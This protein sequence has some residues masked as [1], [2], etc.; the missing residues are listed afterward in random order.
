L[1]GC[2]FRT[3]FRRARLLFAMLRGHNHRWFGPA[4]P[5]AE[6]RFRSSQQCAKPAGDSRLIFGTQFLPVA[7]ALIGFRS[8]PLP[9]ACLRLATPTPIAPFVV[10]DLRQ[11]IGTTEISQLIY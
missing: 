9:N 5:I 3:N 6:A 1:S 2:K 11:A 7:Q 10:S 4:Q 8:L